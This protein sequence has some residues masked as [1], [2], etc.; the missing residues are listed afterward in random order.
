MEKQQL[1]TK[2]SNLKYRVYYFS[3]Q[4]IELSKMLAANFLTLKGKKSF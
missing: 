4:V 2:S 1:K 3:L